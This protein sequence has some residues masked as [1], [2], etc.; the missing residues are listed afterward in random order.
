MIPFL[1]SA[2][3]ILH[4]DSLPASEA[5][6]FHEIVHSNH[7]SCHLLHQT[8]QHLFYPHHFQHILMY[9]L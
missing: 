7:Y 3:L 6:S 2:F 8:P 1:F 9:Y 5:Y 4:F